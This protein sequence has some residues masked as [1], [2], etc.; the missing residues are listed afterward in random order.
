MPHHSTNQSSRNEKFVVALE[1]GSANAK[2]G[3]AGF[4]PDDAEQ[5]LTVYNCTTLPTVESVRYGRIKNIREV[6]DTIKALVDSIQKK[7]PIEGRTI[8]GLYASVGGQSTKSHTVKANIVLPARA[9]IT[10]EHID[11]LRDVAVRNIPTNEEILSIAPVSFKVDGTSTPRPVGV[12]GTRISAVFTAVTCNPI[13]K[14]DL[15]DIVADRVGLHINDVYARP[16]TIASMALTPQETNAGCM[17]VDFGAE[18]I[19]VAI[20]K[21]YGLQY[22]RTIPLGSRLFTRDLATSLALTEEEAELTKLSMANAMPE[23]DESSPYPE[24]Q[25]KVNSIVSA[26]M[27][28]IIA[29]IAAQPEFAGI[30]EIELPSG[31]ILTGG[32][33]KMKNFARL[34]SAHTRMKVRLATIPTHIMIADP[35]LSATDMLD[36]IALLG[37]AADHARLNEDAECV[38]APEAASATADVIFTTGRDDNK[39]PERDPELDARLAKH[40][41]EPDD[42]HKMEKI[43]NPFNDE[44]DDDYY[45]DNDSDVIDDDKPKRPEYRDR[46]K[47]QKE[48]NPDEN[49]EKIT[50]GARLKIIQ[51]KVN[52]YLSRNANDNSDEM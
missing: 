37:V 14:N 31:I 40:G 32:G 26:R 25:E 5:S 8:T 51:S 35:D 30:S 17:L 44:T 33:A 12:A 45:D 22:L 2:I 42:F 9:E 15:I 43:D 46:I 41:Y 36:L 34:L 38:S 27:A 21:H 7:Y 28:D 10:E 20:Y 13:N 29:N 3:I 1:I 49:V 24:V 6:T 47:K 50:W 11:R 39:E 52:D 23:K 19:T 18:T 16:L 48:K 4:D